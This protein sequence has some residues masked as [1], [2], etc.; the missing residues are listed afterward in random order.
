M[1]FMQQEAL[2]M[3][4]YRVCQF[5]NQNQFITILRDDLENSGIWQRPL[6]MS[7]LVK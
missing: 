1:K 5:P 4:K 3:G 2:F 7:L 6:I